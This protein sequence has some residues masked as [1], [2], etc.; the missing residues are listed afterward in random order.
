MSKELDRL[1][2]NID[3][4][5]NYYR[6][7]EMINDFKIVETR[8]NVVN[9][10]NKVLDEFSMGKLTPFDCIDKIDKIVNK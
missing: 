4:N 6:S 9:E 3:T 10:I 8:L 5:T 2:S 1:I 7:N